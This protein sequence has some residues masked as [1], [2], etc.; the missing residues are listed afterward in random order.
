MCVDLVHQHQHVMLH[1]VREISVNFE[2]PLEYHADP[3]FLLDPSPLTS[4]GE[5]LISA[6]DEPR[7]AVAFVVDDRRTLSPVARALR[8][9]LD[10][11]TAKEQQK[12]Q[13]QGDPKAAPETLK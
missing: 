7:R 5:W 2:Q 13:E 1:W 9:T 11:A 6:G 8:V 4:A 3:A 10:E 12:K